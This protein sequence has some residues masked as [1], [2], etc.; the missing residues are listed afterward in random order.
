MA[1]FNLSGT[2]LSLPAVQ[3]SPVAIS[4]DKSAWAGL[5]YI[6]VRL[7][8][9]V[10][11]LRVHTDGR[12]YPDRP[13]SAAQGAWVA[14]G[15]V[16]LTSA[17]MASSRSLPTNDPRSMA[18]FTHTGIAI[19]PAQCVINLGLASAKFGGA[20]GGIQAEYVSGPAFTFKPLAGKHW[21]GRA[22]MA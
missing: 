11:G 1:Q 8:S 10:E 2:L 6:T 20:G 17:Q 14:L 16:I 13:G 5:R 19:L 7:L 18:A 4:R 22:G 3:I 12:S 15:D 9:A 21:H